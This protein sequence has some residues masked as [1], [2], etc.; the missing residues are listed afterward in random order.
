VY[1]NAKFSAKLMPKFDLN[2]LAT[3]IVGL[4]PDD[5][6]KYLKQQEPT[7]LSVKFDIFPPIPAQVQ[8]LPLRK[9]AISLDV[10]AK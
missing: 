10:T 9:E 7:I 4:T 1:F 6:E 8:R 2:S 5:A 3:K